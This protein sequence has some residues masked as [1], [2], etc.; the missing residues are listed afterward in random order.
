ML[1]GVLRLVPGNHGRGH[2]MHL[3]GMCLI[4]G[5]PPGRKKDNGRHMGRP[6]QGI[7]SNSIRGFPFLPAFEG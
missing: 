2:R 5:V 6:R 7:S 3:Y 4:Q 1:I